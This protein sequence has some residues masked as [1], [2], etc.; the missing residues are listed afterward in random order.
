MTDDRCTEI[1]AQLKEAG[2]VLDARLATIGSSND[3]SRA[4]DEQSVERNAETRRE[5]FTVI[6]GGSAVELY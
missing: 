6:E 3:Y 4:V 2:A 1:L 5:A